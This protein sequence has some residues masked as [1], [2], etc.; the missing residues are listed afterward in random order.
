MKKSL[1]NLSGEDRVIRTQRSRS[2]VEEPVIAGELR[3]AF[4]RARRLVAN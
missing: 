3:K 4:G 1:R 2:Y